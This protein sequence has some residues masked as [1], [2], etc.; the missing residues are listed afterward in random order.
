[1]GSY[2]LVSKPIAAHTHT[3]TYAQR[4]LD[5]EVRRI[6]ECCIASVYP[7]APTSHPKYQT[8]GR[9]DATLH[10]SQM[11]SWPFFPLPL[12]TGYSWFGPQV[13][14]DTA[15]SVA[16]QDR[17]R[18]WIWGCRGRFSNALPTWTDLHCVPIW[19]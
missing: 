13:R 19:T 16:L 9:R 1:M 2:N 10:K 8:V 5:I 11:E 15:G 4:L 12:Y 3:H 7:S 14:Q 6:V 17:W 18:Q